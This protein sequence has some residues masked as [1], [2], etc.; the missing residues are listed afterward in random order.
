[1]SRRHFIFILFLLFETSNT[2]CAQL[3]FIS[4]SS[5]KAGI[6]LVS[7]W[8]SLGFNDSGW[9]K[10]AS[11]APHPCTP[12]IAGTQAMWWTSDNVPNV[13]FRKSFNLNNLV[14]SATAQITADNE[15]KLYVN[16]M[17]A[18]TGNNWG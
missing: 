15:F 16:G 4:D 7:G 8:D 3:V 1:M 17:L 12:V 14:N 18:G 2:A 10:A 13:Y 9:V 6:N 5:W 11:P